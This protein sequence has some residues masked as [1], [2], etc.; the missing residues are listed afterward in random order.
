MASW[1]L[2]AFAQGATAR[3]FRPC[4]QDTSVASAESGACRAVSSRRSPARNARDEV[5]SPLRSDRRK[6]VTRLELATSS[7]ARKCISVI[8]LTTNGICKSLYQ[9]ISTRA[10]PQSGRTENDRRQILA[11]KFTDAELNC[12]ADIVDYP[13]AAE[14]F[15]FEHQEPRM[16]GP[17]RRFGS[18][19]GGHD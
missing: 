2:S 15:F 11:G 3:R 8:I 16:N 7:L 12:Q 1:C 10:P 17:G 13:R 14:E 5:G 18:T 6:R 19:L 4:G 9:T